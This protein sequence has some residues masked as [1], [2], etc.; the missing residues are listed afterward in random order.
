MT[1]SMTAGMVAET[2]GAPV[3]EACFRAIGVD[4]RILATREAVLPAAR[5]LA[6]ARLA[7]LDTVAS[8]FRPDSEVMR[9]SVAPA[10]PGTRTVTVPASPLLCDLVEDALWAAE[11][12]GGVVD[13]TLGRAMEAAGYDADLAVVRARTTV[14]GRTAVA[15]PSTLADLRVDRAAGTLTTAAGALLDLGATAKATTAD[16]IAG[17]LAARCPGGFLVDL[18]GDIAVSGQPPAGGWVIAAGAEAAATDRIGITTQGVATSGTD[19]RRWYVDGDLRHHLLDPGTGQPVAH[20]WHQVTCVG[21]SALEANTASTAACVLA[22]RAVG[23][24]TERGIPARLVTDDGVVVRSPGWP[25]PQQ[26][27]A[28]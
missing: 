27:R 17:D 12:T 28:S 15:A 22:D 11:V 23:W 4:C 2:T 5:E 13:P 9:L 7:Q 18:G 14:G 19:R 25:R 8:R 26:G 21:A 24:L 1:G 6:Q 20:T 10:A 16:R 3:A